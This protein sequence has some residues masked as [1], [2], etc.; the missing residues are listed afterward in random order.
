ME[1]PVKRRRKNCSKSPQESFFP[2]DLG[3]R[4]GQIRKSEGGN[5]HLKRHYFGP[6]FPRLPSSSE[7]DGGYEGSGPG[8]LAPPPSPDKEK[9]ANTLLASSSEGGERGLCQQKE[10]Y[11]STPSAGHCGNDGGRGKDNSPPPPSAFPCRLLQTRGGSVPSLF[12][13]GVGFLGRIKPNEAKAVSESRVGPV[14]SLF[15]YESSSGLSMGP[16][17]FFRGVE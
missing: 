1:G 12:G 13:A 16:G 5:G 17:T 11:H 8:V 10:W 4:R 6:T 14:H 7:D 3:A 15:S 9:R 2:W